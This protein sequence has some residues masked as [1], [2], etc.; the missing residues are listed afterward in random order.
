[1]RII[2]ILFSYAQKAG[3]CSTNVAAATGSAKEIPRAPGILQPDELARLLAA[4]C[5]QIL[6]AVAIGAFAGLRTAELARLDWTEVKLEDGFIEVTA[7]N[8]K[9]SRR[10]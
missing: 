1:R 3:Y 8:A 9:S 6:A 2:V 5:P 7:A 10:R 4:C